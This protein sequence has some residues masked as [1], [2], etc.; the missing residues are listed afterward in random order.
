MYVPTKISTWTKLHIINL[1]IKKKKNKEPKL[2]D[3]T[4]AKCYD[5][6]INQRKKSY[7]RESKRLRN[8]KL[9]TPPFMKETSAGF[10]I[11]L[12]NLVKASFHLIQ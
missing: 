4:Y 10:N 1:N 8:A 12:F 5:C 7:S 3:K 6:Y 11:L 2:G 9:R